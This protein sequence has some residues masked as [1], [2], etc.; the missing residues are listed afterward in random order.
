MNA[1]F[2][3]VMDE[4]YSRGRPNYEFYEDEL[5]GAPAAPAAAAL[6]RSR[7]VTAFVPP[8]SVRAVAPAHAVAAGEP[9]FNFQKKLQP[10]GTL[11]LG[12][13][14]GEGG[15]DGG[16]GACGVSGD[17]SDVLSHVG[18]SGR[19][20]QPVIVVASFVMKLPNLGGLARTCEVFGAEALVVH[21]VGVAAEPLFQHL[22]MSAELSMPMTAVPHDAVCAFLAERRAAGYTIVGVEQAARSVPLHEALLPD[23]MVLVL[24]GARAGA[25]S[26]GGA[27]LPPVTSRR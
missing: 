2:V 7:R 11:A 6:P 12:G 19:R 27:T 13:G 24:G 21:D 1:A 23:R 26:G 14:H 3:A 10:A 17:A 5:P 18:P 15:E 4:Y 20:H 8:G 22:A 25:V 16:G 9:A